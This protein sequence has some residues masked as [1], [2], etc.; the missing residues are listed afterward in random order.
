MSVVGLEA[1]GAPLEAVLRVAWDRRGELGPWFASYLRYR[2]MQS[3]WSSQ[4]ADAL[5]ALLKDSKLFSASRAEYLIL[6]MYYREKQKGLTRIP[7][8]LVIRLMIS[9]CLDESWTSGD[10]TFVPVYL[11]GYLGLSSGK[12][13]LSSDQVFDGAVRQRAPFLRFL[14]T[15][16]PS[17]ERDGLLTWTRETTIK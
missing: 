2:C 5:L 7:D 3:P 8:M 17:I 10:R 11:H 4:T 9:W 15:S 12:A 16:P 6:V 14:E 13:A 1:A